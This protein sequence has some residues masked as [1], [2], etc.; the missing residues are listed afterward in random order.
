MLAGDI[1]GT[2]TALGLFDD[3][4]GPGHP[5]AEETFP[6]GG[7]GSLEE[8]A[9]EFLS[10]AQPGKIEAA[11][12]AIAGPILGNSASVTN[13]PWIVQSSRLAAELDIPVVKL[14]NDVQAVACSI[15]FLDQSDL[16]ALNAGK[17]VAEGTAAV[18]AAG[19]GLGEAVLTWNET[20]YRSHP[21]E[22]GHTDFG[23][24]NEHQAGLWR[25]VSRKR[26]H[27]SWEIV[28]SGI[29]I[30]N[31]YDYLKSTGKYADTSKLK[32]D[33]AFAED[34]TP[35]I[36]NTALRKEQPCPL[37]EDTL[38]MFVAILGAES[39]NLALK[40]MAT[41]GVYLGGGIPPRIL[42]ALEGETFMEAFVAKGR[43]SPMMRDIPV[44]VILNPKAALMGAAIEAIEVNRRKQSR[45]PS[46]G[47]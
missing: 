34:P 19:T 39:G 27:V 40:T 18:I 6:S 13:L 42:K 46:P 3:E 41:G 30:P 31:I 44:Y 33:S 22:G 29:G 32:E 21:T 17:P 28:C 47:R 4:A 8:I 14:I 25:Y 1:G 10:R 36:L 9:A 12:F 5:L 20:S 2:K 37:C 45:A 7:Y 43:L 35:V 15:P 38:D 23:P 16:R 26:D 11:C 24:A